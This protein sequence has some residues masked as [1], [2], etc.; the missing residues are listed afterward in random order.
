MNTHVF[1]R[2]SV[3]ND[4]HRALGT[5]FES[6]WNDM[7]LPQVYATDPYFETEAVRCRAGLFDV[8]SLRLLDVSGS[9]ALA[10]LNEMLTSD[11][12]KL[13]P[14]QSAISNIVDEN[15][16]LI[17]D[18]L[19]Y[20]IA[21][22]VYRVSHGSG[23]LEDV[24]PLVTKDRDVKVRKDNDTHILSLQGPKALEILAPHTPFDLAKLGYF[25]HAKTTLFGRD[26]TLAR[27]GYSGERGYE[28][29]CSAADAVD[30]WD[31]IL[32]AGEPYGA[33][34]ASWG[35]LDIIRVEAGLLFF[36]YD[37][38]QGDTTPWEVGVAWTVDL[39]KPAF[40]GKEA[41]IRRR[42]EQRVAQVGIEIDHHEAVEAGAK[43]VKDG[44]EVGTVNS[45]IYSQHL[46][47]SIA[48]AHVKPADAAIG[49]EFEVHSAAGT[50]KARV[51]K[52]PFYD[53]LRLRTHPLSERAK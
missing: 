38:P 39:D 14:G 31:A 37:M 26:V 52:V 35:C 45:P 7:P 5:Q 17:D 44:T 22:G 29:F 32:E 25:E 10:A 4:R 30:I 43:L 28:V 23:A 16:S 34:P 40:I 19:I 47:R 51:V 1:S 36:P 12:A 20:C 53:P 42:G 2:Q 48:L 15:G 49:T 50:F 33:I 18:V 41:L 46:M 6:S 21:P 13:A 3:L 9:D 8:S 24:L 11:I 27:G